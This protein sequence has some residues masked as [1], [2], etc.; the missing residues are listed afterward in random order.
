[1]SRSENVSLRAFSLEVSSNVVS[2]S[3]LWVASRDNFDDKFR[4]SGPRVLV[5]IIL[6]RCDDVSPTVRL[7][8]L[9]ALC[10]LLEVLDENSPA[11][12]ID[13]F[14][15]FAMGDVIKT[16]KTPSTPMRSDSSKS[17]VP[18][19]AVNK[20]ISIIDLLRIRC[21]DEKPMVRAKAVQTFGQALSMQWPKNTDGI[22]ISTYI[23]SALLLVTK[24]TIYF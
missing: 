23:E 3:Y 4:F 18:S 24:F 2:K 14:F 9:S 1:M 11:L 20:T 21:Y 5:E 15:Q 22:I 16:V 7:R 10:D 6:T 17:P 8:G 13:T 19:K 12:L